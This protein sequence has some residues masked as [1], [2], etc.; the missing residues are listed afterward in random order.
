MSA[1]QAAVTFV[2][3]ANDLSNVS[4]TSN[5]TTDRKNNDNLWAQRDGYGEESVTILEGWDVN[6]NVPVLTLTLSNLTV[7]QTYDVYVNY[8]RFTS[9]NNPRGGIRGSLDG[10]S[11]STFNGAGGTE[12]TVGFAEETGHTANGDQ[13]GLRGYLGTAIADGSGQIQI[14][15]DDDGLDGGIEERVWFDGASYEASYEAIPEPSAVALLALGGVALTLRR[16]K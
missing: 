4:T 6:E 14:F 15:V 11:F 7:G 5:I 2:S 1:S 13:V 3:V 9:N 10:T 12:G 8:I 16:R